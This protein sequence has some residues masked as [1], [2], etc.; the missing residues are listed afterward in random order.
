M[1]LLHEYFLSLVSNTI[2]LPICK[3][4]Y[5]YQ[6]VDTGLNHRVSEHYIVLVRKAG[7]RPRVLL[8]RFSEL[9]LLEQFQNS[10]RFNEVRVKGFITST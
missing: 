3:L 5:R 4:G 8:L 10:V 6:L 1:F 2:K 9:F 7:R